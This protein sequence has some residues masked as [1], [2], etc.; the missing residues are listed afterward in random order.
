MYMNGISFV[1]R[2]SFY[3]DKVVENCFEGMEV[4]C[5]KALKNDKRSAKC[6][7]FGDA[8]LKFLMNL[9]KIFKF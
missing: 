3:S 1:I 2:L 7:V 8:K 4:R 9:R 6:F 5:G